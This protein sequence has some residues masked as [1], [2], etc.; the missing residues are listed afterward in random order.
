L[1]GAASAGAASAGG[2]GASSAAG[3]SAA[4][5]V[6]GAAAAAEHP[7]APQPELL[8]PAEPHDEVPHDK[9]LQP[10]VSH[11]GVH[12]GA[13]LVV[14]AGAHELL[15]LET[16][17]VLQ[18]VSQVGAGTQLEEHEDTVHA[19]THGVQEL[20][21]GAQVLHELTTVPQLLPH[22]LTTVPHEL[23]YTTGDDPQDDPPQLDELT[24]TEPLL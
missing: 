14:Q 23:E 4:A 20:T 11:D 19:E 21:T 18:D 5:A 2:A 12:V 24:T 13:Q 8:H 1:A 10:D 7:P 17:G 3:G 9:V 22:E 15:Q 6:C 16:H